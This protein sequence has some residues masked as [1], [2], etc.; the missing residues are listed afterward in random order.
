MGNGIGDAAATRPAQGPVVGRAIGEM[1][2]IEGEREIGVGN[3]VKAAMVNGIETRL[4]RVQHK[5]QWLAGQLVKW[6]K[7]KAKKGHVTYLPGLIDGRSIT[8]EEAMRIQ[9]G[10]FLKR[11]QHGN[12]NILHIAARAGRDT[13]VAEAL[14]RFP[15]LS[16]QVNSQGDTPLLVAARFGHLQVVKTLADPNNEL[17]MQGDT[18]PAVESGTNSR[19][20]RRQRDVE[21]GQ[22][23]HQLEQGTIQ[24]NVA[25]VENETNSSNV[26]RRQRDVE[27]GLLDDQ[28][29][30]ATSLENGTNSRD[31]ATALEN[32][33]NSS[34][35]RRPR[36]V[37]EGLDDHQLEQG[38]LQDGM[39]TTVENGT[40]SKDMAT[41]LENETNSSSSRRPR[42]VEEGLDDHQLDVAIPSHWRVTN[43]QGTIITTALH[44]ALRNWH[45]DVA[46]YL[47]GL[48][49][50]MATFDNFAGESPL[51]LAAESRCE[52]FMSDILLSKRPYSTKGPDGLNALHASRHC[53]GTIISELIKQ[54]PD[55][56]RKLDNHGKAAIHHAVEADYWVLLDRMLKA[57][58]SIALFPWRRSVVHV[59][60]TEI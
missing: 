17:P 44:E 3:M 41:A 12:N 45:Q 7:S 40:N 43:E 24:D 58:P 29:E 13:F 25:T 21:E 38:T 35:S 10:I 55:L 11:T 50:E 14:R 56:M 52:L 36:D 48:K 59:S 15:F 46:R 19:S 60:T 16:D 30:Q 26:S 54:N 51:F 47:L 5:V 2:Q 57:D 33:T 34:S 53:C 18:T 9:D 20:S 27:E 39:A 37:E 49:P 8:E 1:A 4:P 23:H 32:E 28:L 22:V 31:M 42:D 6:P